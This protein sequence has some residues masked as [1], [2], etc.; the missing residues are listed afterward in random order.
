MFL[1]PEFPK[2][3]PPSHAL[4]RKRALPRRAAQHVRDMGRNV[5]Q[6]MQ[7]SIEVS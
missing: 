7:K 6:R 4:A 5:A 2:L 1:G 3:Y